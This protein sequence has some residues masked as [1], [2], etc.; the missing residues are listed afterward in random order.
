MNKLLRYSMLWMLALISAATNAVVIDF[1]QLSITE[2]TTGFTLDVTIDGY[3]YSFVAEKNDGTTKPTQNAKSKDIR[4][5]AQNSLTVSGEGMTKMVF[6]MSDKGLKQWGTVTADKGTVTVDVTAGTTT[7][8]S[9]EAVSSVTLTVG[10]S[11]DYG[12]ETSKTSGQFDFISLAINE[13]GGSTGGG[14]QPGGGDTD[15]VIYN[16]TLVNNTGDFTIKDVNLPAELSY[17]WQNNNYGWVASAFKGVKYSAESWIISPAMVLP[18]E[19]AKMIFD[20]ALNFGSRE[21]IGVYISKDQE[22]WTELTVAN[23]P[24]GTGWT[25]ISSGDIDLS[26]FKG[27]KVYIAFKYISTADNAPTWEI[28]NLKVTGKGDIVGPAKAESAWAND[29]VEVKVGGSVDNTFTTNSNGAITYTSS[30]TDVATIDATGKVTVVGKGVAEI[31]AE[32]AETDAFLASSESFKLCVVEHDGTIESPFSCAEVSYLYDNKTEEVWIKG[33]IVGYIDGNSAAGFTPDV[34]RDTIQ[35]EIVIAD[36][37]DETE[38]AN[39][40]AVQLPTGAV[41]EALDLFTN[42]GNFGK[43]VWLQGKLQ[44]YFG[45]AGMKSTSAFS[46]DG[47]TGINNVANDNKR[48]NVIYNLNGQRLETLQKGINII[49]GKKV[50]VK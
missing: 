19:S 10:T 49:N 35:T 42:P 5:Y 34:P 29:Y 14:D 3:G 6:K 30:N 28:K 44:K 32:T 8:V 21:G 7:W 40:V 43:V 23:W 2:T 41:R 50:F 18:T 15:L 20:H 38:I 36:S 17:I 16:N 24:E 25:F 33:Y 26:A 39:C 4:L 37:E 9:T 31:T 22:N 11:N 47:V 13:D 1:T 48:R 46:F 27:Q 12:T 45:M